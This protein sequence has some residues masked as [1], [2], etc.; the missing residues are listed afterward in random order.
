MDRGRLNAGAGMHAAGT[1]PRSGIAGAGP[2]SSMT[3]PLLRAPRTNCLDTNPLRA[4][5]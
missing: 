2:S 5:R 3:H 1:R 4:L